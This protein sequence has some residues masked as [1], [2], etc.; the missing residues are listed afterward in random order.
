MFL[1]YFSRGSNSAFAE[2]GPGCRCI[3][4]NPIHVAAV[5]VPKMNTKCP[6]RTSYYHTDWHCTLDIVACRI[7]SPPLTLLQDLLLQDGS[8]DP[9]EQ[10]EPKMVP[11]S[12]GSSQ[13][14]TW[15][16]RK[17]QHVRDVELCGFQAGL[18][19]RRRTAQLPATS[20]LI[21]IDKR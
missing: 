8:W 18:G 12:Q 2:K 15:H 11:G 16:R 3:P 17:Y 5:L 21:R 19:R 6:P 7:R 13:D 14:N 9:E 4:R 1:F 10:L 20:H